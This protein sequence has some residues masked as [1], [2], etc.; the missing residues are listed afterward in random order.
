MSVLC[1]TF[2]LSIAVSAEPRY[3]DNCTITLGLTYS[4]SGASCYAKIKGSAGTTGI[5]NCTLSLEDSSG[6]VVKSW[7]N[8][9]VSG[10]IL[11]V[12]KTTSSVV[13]GE[14]YTLSITATVTR[15]GTSET[16][17]DSITKTY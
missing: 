6:N 10:S 8:L 7:T 14:T 12:S 5:S 16:V 1:I 17:S 13:K 4:S 11:S 3:S 15:N 2:C 9:S